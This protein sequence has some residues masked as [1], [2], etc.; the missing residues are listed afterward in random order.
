MN[1]SYKPELYNICL[2]KKHGWAPFP[3]PVSLD[4]SY[5]AGQSCL[6]LHRFKSQGFYKDSTSIIKYAY[7]DPCFFGYVCVRERK[8]CLLK[9]SIIWPLHALNSSITDVLS[10]Q[11]H[12]AVEKFFVFFYVVM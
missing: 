12:K 1:H 5:S 3:P 7:P 2:C 11:A 10:S 8:I 9:N 6:I 4:P